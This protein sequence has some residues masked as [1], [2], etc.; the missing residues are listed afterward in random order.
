MRRSGTA[1]R[2]KANTRSMVL[3]LG[4]KVGYF[5]GKYERQLSKRP[6]AVN[7]ATSAVLWGIAD[8]VAQRIGEQRSELD[9]KR[10]VVTSGFGAGFMGPMGHLW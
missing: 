7:A 6:Y 5:W 1:S 9:F 2:N 10:A 8:C 3:G 4:S